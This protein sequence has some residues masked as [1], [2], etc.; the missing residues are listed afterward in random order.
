MR[1]SFNSLHNPR[2]FTLVLARKDGTKLGTLPAHHLKVHGEMNAP[3]SAEFSVYKVNNN[4]TLRIWN[5]IQDCKLM[6]IRELDLW[7][8]IHVQTSDGNVCVKSVTATSLAEDELS[9]TNVYKME[10]N[11]ETDIK[12]EDYSPTVFY[13]SADASR[14]LLDRLLA[15]TPHYRIVSVPASLRTIQRSFSFDGSTIYDALQDVAKELECYIDFSV[16]SNAEGKPDRAIRVYDLKAYCLECRSRGE[17]EKVCS[18]CGSENILAPY[19]VDMGIFVS[20]HNLTDEVA[21][22]TNKDAIK[23]CFKLEAGDELMTATAIN[24]NPNGSSYLWYIPQFMK[25]DMPQELVEKIAS[26]D[27]LNLY[28]QDEHVVSPTEDLRTSYNALVTKYLGYKPELVALPEKIVGFPA[29]M[30]NYYHTIDFNLL[31]QSELMPTIETVGTT[32]AEQAAKLTAARISPVAVYSIDYASGATVNSAVLAMAKAQVDYRYQVRI[33]GEPTYSGGV[34]RGHFVVT[35]YHN[36][37]DTA[38][39]SEISVTIT[40]NYESYVQQMLDKSLANNTNTATDIVTLFGMTDNNFKNELKKYSLNRLQSFYD[41]CQACIN[42]L[43]EQGCGSNTTWAESDQ[44]L[45]VDLYVPYQNKLGYISSEIGLRESEITTITSVQDEIIDNRN[46]IQNAL[47]FETYLGTDL[48]HTFIAYRREDTYSNPNYISDGLNNAQLF[49]RAKQFVELAKSDLYKSANLQHTISSTLKNLLVM[50]EFDKL[51]DNFELGN[52]IHIEC[53]GNIYRIRLLSFDIDFDNLN[54]LSVTFSDVREI[55]DD[56]K[57]IRDVLD[58][59]R[60]MGSTYDN[61]KNQASKGKD[62]RDELDDWS[63]HGLAL[64][65]LKILN[66]ADN[67]D[68]VFD[69]HGMLFR[70]YQPLLDN[71]SDEQLKIINSTIAITSDNWHT[72]RTAIGSHYYIDPLTKEVTYGYGIN[73][74]VL[75]GKIILGE[76]LGIYN[77]GAT[78]QFNRN[79]LNITNGS[80]TFMVSPNDETNL[81]KI[82]S[83]SESLFTFTKSG[84]LYIKGEVVATKGEIGGCSIVN[85]KLTID[86]AHITSGTIDTARIPTLTADK[87]DAT[88]LKVAAANITGTLKIGQL[89]STVA[90]T[91]DIPTDAEI[92]TITNNTIQTTSVTASN[93]KVKA[94]NISGTLTIGQLPSTVAETSDIP[95]N[96]SEL[97]NDSK[98]QTETGVTT[99]I[100]GTVTADYVNGL[101]CSFTKGKIGGW[102]ISSNEFYSDKAGVSSSDDYTK[103]S[104]VTSGSTS[105]VRFYCG[106]G[107]R[108]DGKFV[109]LDDGSLYAS[110]ANITGNIT[111]TTGTIGDLSISDGSLVYTGSREGISISTSGFLLYDSS[112]RINISTSNITSIENSVVLSGSSYANRK[113]TLDYNGLL[114]NFSNYATV[115]NYDRHFVV[116]Y[117]GKTYIKYSAVFTS[118]NT[119]SSTRAELIGTWYYGTSGAA[120]ASARCVKNNITQFDNRHDVLFDN[121]QPKT[122][123]YKSGESGR[124]HYGYILDELY[125]AMNAAG[126]TSEECGAY[127]LYDKDNPDGE[128]GIRYDEFVSLNTWQIQLLKPR[129]S[130]LEEKVE[131]LEK[132]NTELKEQLSKLLNQ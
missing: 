88:D 23:N 110:A 98:Y 131:A 102:T 76:Q 105:P 86:S 66:S 82:F 78:L 69:E 59:S 43:I 112:G 90:E 117:N 60:A 128:G 9:Q 26:Y 1:L 64:T 4:H 53:D 109:V 42:I 71:Y 47:N 75:I 132:E 97:T 34:W 16:H 39:S 20:K 89:P 58:N 41:S 28:Y 129:V 36:E 14:S 93:L 122:F 3:W 54:D 84:N 2:P 107:N 120:Y 37:E 46:A 74:E 44:D 87:I 17:F 73:G 65:N 104:L 10:I 94:A 12:R 118:G 121:L 55:R 111:A 119:W 51:L 31:L 22:E 103:A 19:G 32:A 81:V 61:V 15:K 11:T 50:K 13:D 35:N 108:V 63:T 62:S 115:G 113:I 101:S 77:S 52:F 49:E 7:Y 124:I 96:V 57:D 38:T 5:E 126:I 85:G 33:Q 56:I 72:V 100:N 125:N 30:E 6:W 27:E 67:Q 18:E 106:N 25:D 99:I 130:T 21:F 45:Y 116:G 8:E 114:L 68:Y 95:T 83:S 48:W 123:S 29:L 70:K 127:C 92:T 80:Y 24:C 79:G 40:D 91:S